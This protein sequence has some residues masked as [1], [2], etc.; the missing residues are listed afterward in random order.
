MQS[1]L[2]IDCFVFVRNHHRL[3]KFESL[4]CDC[5]LIAVIQSNWLMNAPL[6]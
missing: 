6:V 1:P 3:M 5:D 2:R 4:I